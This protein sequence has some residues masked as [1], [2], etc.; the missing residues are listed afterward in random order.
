MSDPHAH[1]HHHA[2]SHSHHNHSHAPAN[3]NR[4]FIIGL[5]LNVGFVLIEFI[6]GVYANSIALIADAG[7]N[8]SDVLGL[9]LAWGAS[10]LVTRKPSRSKT[11]GMRKS[12]IVAAF[13]NAVS[14]LVVTGGIAWEAIQRF[15]RPGEVQGDIIIGVAI[16]GIAINTIT[17]LMFLSGRDRDLNIRAAFLHMMADALVSVGVVIAGIGILLT[18]WL[19]LDPAFSLLISGLIIYNTWSLLQESFHLIVDGV[20]KNIDEREVRS[21]LVNCPGVERIHD[22]HIWAMST[23]ETALTAHLVMPE[24]HPGDS[25]LS[26]VGRALHDNF[27]IDHCTLQVEWGDPNYLCALEPEDCV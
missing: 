24:G 26:Q 4:A 13:L 25:F 21:Y 2:H 11:Y 7:H 22:L 14:L 16:V 19:W 18:R 10:L 15:L 12:S 3:Y 17:A 1:H 5:V 6:F 20:P 8:L 27:D 9:L 23:T